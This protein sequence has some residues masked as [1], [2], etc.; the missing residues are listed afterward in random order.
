MYSIGGEHLEVVAPWGIVVG[1]LYCAVTAIILL[2]I[3]TLS[4][5]NNTQFQESLQKKKPP[6]NGTAACSVLTGAGNVKLKLFI[7]HAAL[8]AVNIDIIIIYFNINLYNCQTF[9]HLQKENHLQEAENSEKHTQAILK[10]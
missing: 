8:L 4:K 3:I 7:K 2:A 1:L 5:V 9:V 6:S 10:W